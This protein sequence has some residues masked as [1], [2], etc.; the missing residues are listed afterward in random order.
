MEYAY[1]KGPYLEPTLQL[2]AG[3]LLGGKKTKDSA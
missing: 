3:L 1:D 2:D